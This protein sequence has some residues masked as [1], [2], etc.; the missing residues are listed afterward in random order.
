MIRNPRFH[1]RRDAQAAVNP[2]QVVEREVK[3]EGNRNCGQMA[4]L[5][6]TAEL[7]ECNR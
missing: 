1:G 2:A 6:V 4:H 3:A 7:A 5:N